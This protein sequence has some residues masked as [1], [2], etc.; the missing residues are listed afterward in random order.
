VRLVRPTEQ[1]YL[2]F[3]DEQATPVQAFRHQLDFGFVTEGHG[4]SG[5]AQGPVVFVGFQRKPNG[6]TWESFKGLDLR[7]RIVLLQ[8][9]NA[10]RILRPRP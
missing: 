9:G 10:R 1:P 5:S 3:L 6:Y 4:G 7:E 2:A 8:E